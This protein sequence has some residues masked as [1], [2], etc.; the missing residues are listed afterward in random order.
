[1]KTFSLLCVALFIGAFQG[2]A[3]KIT[4]IVLLT[5]NGVTQDLELATSFIIVKQYPD[6]HFERLDYKKNGPLTRVR[7]YSD[8]Q[9]KNLH[10]TYLEYSLDGAITLYGE[11]ENNMKHGLWYTYN[12]TGKVITELRYERDSIVEI[13]DP[14]RKDSSVAYPDERE[15]SFPGGGKAWAKY[16]IKSLQ[17]DNPANRSLKGGN[18]I[19]FFKVSKDGSISHSYI[20]RSAEYVLDEAALDIIRKSPKWIPAFQNGREVNAYR[21]QPITFAK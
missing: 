2:H 10:G 5:P 7:N 6:F 15:A 18:V 9:L 19:V 14:D 17:K 4:N 16:L 3:Q 12:D 21:R 13:I 8:E 11:Y 20:S 1:M